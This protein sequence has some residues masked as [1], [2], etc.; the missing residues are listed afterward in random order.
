MVEPLH[1]R[2]LAWAVTTCC[3]IILLFYLWNR[4]RY[5]THPVLFLYVVAVV[6]QS[7]LAMLV[8]EEWGYSTRAY[9][10]VAWG[11]QMLV[12]CA[13]GWAVFELAH[14]SLGAYRGIWALAWRV[15]FSVGAV[16]LAYGLLFAHGQWTTVVMN[17]GRGMELSIAAIIV[18]LL[19]F[20]RYYRVPIA[21]LDRSLAIGFCLY[22]CFYVANFSL[23]EPH[24]S[25]RA[26]FWNFLDISAFL[27]SLLL[28]IV[29]VRRYPGDSRAEQRITIPSE[30]YGQLSENLNLR[31]HLLNE[32]L[33]ELLRPGGPRL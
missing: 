26:Y 13:R 2:D 32:H 15:L 8:Y 11:T 30:V 25:S 12:I 5:S 28:W 4:R 29:A 18:T 17:A 3:E 6:A 7:A 10:V 33:A 20:T 19:L 1:L 24:L 22:S 27:A 31:L 23:F 9:W 21:P 16:V 14:R